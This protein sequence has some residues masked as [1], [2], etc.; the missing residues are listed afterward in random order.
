M[1]TVVQMLTKRRE[2]QA[3]E[4]AT[5]PVWQPHTCEVSG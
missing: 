4:R 5:A 3:Q 1:P 2:V